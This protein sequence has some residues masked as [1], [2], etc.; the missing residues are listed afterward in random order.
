ML[1]ALVLAVAIAAAARRAPARNRMMCAWVASAGVC[2]IYAIAQHYGLDVVNWVAV[3]PAQRAVGTLGGPIY[4][5][6]FLA[7]SF[8]FAVA[9][10]R[11]RRPP[12]YLV[13]AMALTVVALAV[14]YSRA[15][16]LGALAGLVVT[17]YSAGRPMARPVKRDITTIL[18]VAA[19]AA[20]L[21]W[22]RWL[23]SMP[24]FGIVKRALAVGLAVASLAV[25]GD[26]RR[27]ATGAWTRIATAT[28]SDTQAATVRRTLWTVAA[29]LV[30]QRPFLGY[31]T[32]GFRVASSSV[33]MDG[34]SVPP[35]LLYPHQSAHS[36]WYTA[37]VEGGV[38]G[39][40]AWVLVI[41]SLASLASD[42]ARAEQG[43]LRKR[44]QADQPA[45]QSATAFRRAD[46]AAAVFGGV[47]AFVVQG[48][49]TPRGPVTTLGLVLCW[50]LACSLEPCKRPQLKMPA[51]P[52]WIVGYVWC[53]ICL[54]VFGG[55]MAAD[56][57]EWRGD[58]AYTR[59][60]LEAA[61]PLYRLAA[62]CNP[63]DPG[64]RRAWGDAAVELAATEHG[65]DAYTM[66][67]DAA[68]AYS[69][70]VAA[71]PRNGVWRAGLAQALSM[72]DAEKAL[73]EAR[74]A[75]H[76]APT[77]ALAW[78]SLSRAYRAGGNEHGELYAL[79]ASVTYRPVNPAPYVRL[80]SVFRDHNRSD[81]GDRVIG[82][83]EEEWPEDVT[84]KAWRTPIA[85]P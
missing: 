21:C 38:V 84:V 39:L 13:P 22:M 2:S 25:Y 73:T 52:V 26:S 19:M 53:A 82:W 85:R 67:E 11:I 31:G 45:V 47:A 68:E 56:V 54:I 6:A 63:T 5:G 59:G 10:S 78:Y 55:G 17:M 14:S 42:R 79:R 80:A 51:R 18:M 70:N 20:P 7:M 57:L 41:L 1:P 62:Q 83:A 32:D 81:L 75:V 64:Y 65:I 72:I 76:D 29:I 30:P 9:V 61:V 43:V 33:A 46:V 4:L 44:G 15:A 66:A 28:S 48:S 77:S 35:P 71:E 8:P 69:A 16:W 23:A 74:R 49:L 58:K 60:D 50:G 40:L 27:P 24:G 36:E 34:V 12:R 37:A 3:N